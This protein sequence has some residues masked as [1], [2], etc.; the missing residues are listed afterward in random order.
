MLKLKMWDVG[1]LLPRHNGD[2]TATGC[3][4]RAC[5][6]GTVASDGGCMWLRRARP[7][8]AT[9]RPENS[10]AH[11]SRLHNSLQP[12]VSHS[13]GARAAKLGGR[14]GLGA[15]KERG[16]RGEKRYIGFE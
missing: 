14:R 4:A 8:A 16:R 11:G 12:T 1:L 5:G 6:G 2:V 9:L 10:G 7:T 15:E 3:S 13:T